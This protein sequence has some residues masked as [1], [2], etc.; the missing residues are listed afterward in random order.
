MQ[1]PF[2]YSFGIKP[3]VHIVNPQFE[4]LAEGFYYE[5]PTE[6]ALMITGVRG[7]GKTVM[8]S[9]LNAVLSERP[10]WI[11]IDLNRERDLLETFAANLYNT[12]GLKKLMINA[13]IDL[14]LFGIGVSLEKKDKSYDIEL[15]IE[16][17][18]NIV[19]R[20]KL[21]VLIT[22]DE[23][24]KS[25]SMK[26]FCQ[27]FQRYIRKQLPVYIVM[28]GLYKDIHSIKTM[29]GCTFLNR[30]PFEIIQPLDINS[31]AIEYSRVL[32]ID[33]TLAVRMAKLT[34]GYSFAFQVLGKL[35]FSKDTDKTLDDLIFQYEG[36]LG[37]Y[38]YNIIWNELS[39]MD[40][41]VVEA[42]ISLGDDIPVKR[43]QLMDKLDIS[44]SMMNR[45]Q[46]RLFEKG[47]ID[48]TSNGYGFYSLALPR[49][50]S[51]IRTYYMD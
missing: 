12:P 8:L 15:A 37:K 11:V 39:E 21:K 42:L 13:K 24:R 40:R 26:V 23:V 1:N 36:E 17:M 38:S 44:S 47:V 2:S 18:L 50:G 45:Y 41:K 4:R 48:T 33:N 27:S 9:E 32:A 20:E 28:T 35:Y 43:K 31:I 5:E 22:I 3:K 10:D 51:Y 14:S 49:F 16:Q 46:T 34:K 29:E 25:D 7:S 19:K 30:A 6:R